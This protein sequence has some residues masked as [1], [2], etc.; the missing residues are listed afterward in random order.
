MLFIVGLDQLSKD[1]KGALL[2]QINAIT[3][4]N[5]LNEGV[6]KGVKKAKNLVLDG[7]AWL[8]GRISEEYKQNIEELNKRSDWDTG[9]LQKAIAQEVGALSRLDPADISRHL[10]KRLVEIAQVDENVNETVLASAII[11]R[12]AK[13]LKIDVRLFA[14][15]SL[16]ENEVFEACVKERISELKKRLEA[17]SPSE[18]ENF[19]KILRDEIAKL[20][21]SDKEAIRNA[22]GLEELSASAIVAFLRSTSSV[23]I[24]QLVLGSFGFG[25]FLFL[26]TTMKA[27][28]LLLGVTFSF[29][30]YTAATT[31]M[32]F[33]LSAPFLIMLAAISGGLILRRTSQQIDD[34][35]A[36]LLIIVGRAKLLPTS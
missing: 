5:V 4:L 20:R 3:G 2:A 28:S 23:T 8:A 19:E 35:L 24:A 9:V 22:I 30:A 33:L 16:L 34:Q 12:A 26:T 15:A 17:M 25:S 11:H 13:A 21:E 14:D 6:Q 27:L 36:K 29:G 7:A 1:E 32:A 18:M 31:I 10:R